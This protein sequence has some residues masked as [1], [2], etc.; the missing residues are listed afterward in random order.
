MMIFA[1]WLLAGL[2]FVFFWSLTTEWR[3]RDDKP[4]QWRR[5]RGVMHLRDHADPAPPMN[6]ADLV[7]RLKRAG[8]K[9][10]HPADR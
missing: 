4:D 2:T 8:Y 10:Q 6:T 3:Y 9:G 5:Y 7:Q 1:L